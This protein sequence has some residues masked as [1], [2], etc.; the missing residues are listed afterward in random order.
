MILIGFILVGAA[1][2]LGIDVAMENSGARL[3]VESFGHTFSQPPWVLLVVG[4]ICGALVVMGLTAMGAGTARRRR[5]WRERRGAIRQRDRLVVQLEELRADLQRAE[6]QRA[7][8][9]VYEPVSP[10]PEGTGATDASAAAVDSATVGA[11]PPD[12]LRP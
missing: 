6:Q 11:Q 5:L 12:V 3:S 4:A 2:A 9:A 10:V 7:P 8:E 1:V